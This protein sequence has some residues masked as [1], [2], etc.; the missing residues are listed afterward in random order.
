MYY[1][2]E[3]ELND[4]A[5]SGNSLNWIFFGLCAGGLLS[6]MGVLLSTEITSPKM[7]ATFIAVTIV[8]GLG[9][10]FFGVNGYRDYR[11]IQKT[12]TRI[13]SNEPRTG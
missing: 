9:T 6:L 11:E 12:L 4:L 8:L 10:L 3:S 2:S 1:A 7:Y 13:K 5:K